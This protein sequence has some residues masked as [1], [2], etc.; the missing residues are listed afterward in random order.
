MFARMIAR[1]VRRVALGAAVGSMM[2]IQQDA[3]MLAA[4]KGTLVGTGT[5]GGVGRGEPLK[6]LYPAIEPY[7]TGRL[8]VGSGHSVYYEQCGNANG[9]PVVFVHGGPGSGCSASNRCFFDPELYRII[10]IDQRGAGRSTPSASLEDNT[11]WD[12]VEDIEHLRTTL[13]IDKWMVFGGSWGS[14]LSLTYAIQHPE[15]VTELVLRGIFM[16]RPLELSFFYQDGASMIF[17]DAWAA[18]EAHIP[19]AERGDMIAAYHKRLT[20][21]D[22]ATRLAAAK[23]WTTWEM[24]TSFAKPNAEQIAKGEDPKF[25]E[26][27]ARIEA[28]YFVN[29]GFFP[30][31]T[32]LLDHVE[33]IRH[34][35][36]FIVQ[37]R[38]DVV[39]PMRSAFDLSQAF[40]EAELVICGQSGHSANEPETISELVMAGDR[41][42]GKRS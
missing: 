12:L 40:P 36:T 26:H 21:T 25:A 31:E 1:S 15:R 10:L 7:M 18:Y 17:P 30:T 20:S 3:S 37:G 4:A 6:T 39:C 34:I 24:C 35:P 27:F 9:K 13:D 11:T 23:Q 42:V 28:H 14:T 8:E 22:E 32:Y 19:P 5:L 33:R 41:F 38:Y 2:T 16:L 29:K